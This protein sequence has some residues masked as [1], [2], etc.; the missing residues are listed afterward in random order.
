MTLIPSPWLFFN[1]TRLSLWVFGKGSWREG[2]GGQ[3]NWDR[4]VKADQVHGS[5]IASVGKSQ[6][7]QAAFGVDGLITL[8][9]EVWLE[10]KVADCIPLF[11]FDQDLKVVG[12][13]HLGWQGL[14]GGTVSQ[15][16]NATQKASGV[17]LRR[18]F[19]V[20]GPSIGACCYEV[21][22]DL[23][24]KFQR[25]YSDPVSFSEGGLPG[26]PGLAREAP[27]FKVNH[28]LNLDLR[29]ACRLDLEKLGIAPARIWSPA[30]CTCCQA[31]RYFSYRGGGKQPDQNNL[32]LIG[33]L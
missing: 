31:E 23:G 9:K 27:L 18:L 21:Q 5:K 22:D 8:A 4:M 17:D 2:F 3:P 19:F 20:L 33:K 16:V 11:L 7:G 10:I 6:L 26:H 32:C 29:L 28:K 15:A 14:L 1:L 12:L 25:K 30:V 24:L 13:V